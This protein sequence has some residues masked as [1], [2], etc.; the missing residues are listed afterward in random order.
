MKGALPMPF[1]YIPSSL[2]CLFLLLYVV[3]P[4]HCP[5]CKRFAGEDN[6]G[7]S[8]Q[9]VQTK[10]QYTKGYYYTVPSVCMALYIPMEKKQV[11]A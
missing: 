2:I 10:L 4:I 7:M 8:V 11:C 3:Y 5:F 9:K 6:M 1:E